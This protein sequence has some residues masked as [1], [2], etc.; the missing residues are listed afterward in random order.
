MVANRIAIGLG[1]IGPWTYFSARSAPIHPD[2][3]YLFLFNGGVSKIREDLAANLHVKVTSENGC[4][5][6][7]YPPFDDSVGIIY[8]NTAIANSDLRKI[9]PE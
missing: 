4:K 9:C 3:E 1:K 6:I 7:L 8:T 2:D 5:R